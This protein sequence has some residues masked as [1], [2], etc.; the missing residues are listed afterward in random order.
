MGAHEDSGALKYLDQ[1]PAAGMGFA[2]DDDG[3]R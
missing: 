3:R 1:Q 2:E